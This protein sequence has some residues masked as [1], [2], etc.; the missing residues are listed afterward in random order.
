MEHL[1]LD[2]TEAIQSNIIESDTPLLLKRNNK[3]KTKFKKVIMTPKSDIETTIIELKAADVI[4]KSEQ[5]QTNLDPGLFTF[6][7]K[8]NANSEIF[9]KHLN[10]TPKKKTSV[11]MIS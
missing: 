2:T 3:K 4:D 9:A 6:R 5:T 8:L 10:R 1:I 11:S 7:P